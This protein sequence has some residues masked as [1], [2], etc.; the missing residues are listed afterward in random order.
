MHKLRQVHPRFPEEDA[1]QEA[2]RIMR[3]GGLVIFP[4]SAL[5]G[6]GVDAFNEKALEKVFQVKG[7]GKNNPLLIL[8]ERIEALDALVEEIP[9]VAFVLMQAFWPGNLTLVFKAKNH[10]PE[11]LTAGTGKIGIRLPRHPVARALVQKAG[12]PIT[13]TS[14]NLSENPAAFS[15]TM[16]PEKIFK[17]AD[18]VLDSGRL[19]GGIGSTVFDITSS[20]PRLIREG[21]L[22][23]AEI[24]KVLHQ[25]FPSKIPPHFY[26]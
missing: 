22:S 5:Y 18:L 17:E 4:T 21:N 2:S 8:V 15:I 9:P 19:S 24:F 1:I 12:G 26:G 3:A 10:L 13:G 14:A 11:L 23:S 25:N 6:M 7:R 16:L 20:P